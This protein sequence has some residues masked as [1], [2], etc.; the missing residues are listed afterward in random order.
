MPKIV[1]TH[2]VTDM[3]VWLSK[4]SERADIITRLLGG[5][6]VVD[7]VAHDGSMT[8]AV[9]AEVDDAEALVQAL[10]A[11]NPEMSSTMQA[12]TVVPPLTIHVER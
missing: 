9:S 7:H 12:H 8:V 10:A 4:A 2:A 1:V 11:P 3:D 6:N 5:R